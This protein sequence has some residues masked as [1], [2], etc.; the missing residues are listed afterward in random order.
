MP[1][2]YILSTATFPSWRPSIPSR[3]RHT[4]RKM[5]SRLGNEP[6]GWLMCA[7]SVSLPSSRSIAATANRDCPLP[8]STYWL[9]RHRLVRACQILILIYLLILG[10]WFVTNVW[11]SDL[12]TLENDFAAYWTVGHM[13]LNGRAGDAYLPELALAAEA[14]YIPDHNVSLPWFYP[15]QAFFL[16]APFALLPFRPFGSSRFRCGTLFFECKTPCSLWLVLRAP[17]F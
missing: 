3:P 7:L 5:V 12:R 16:T 13:V 8:T 2:S 1:H 17:D 9:D 14:E 11:A 6:A 15:P 10:H 4:T